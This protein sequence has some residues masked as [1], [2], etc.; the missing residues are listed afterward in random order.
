MR[1]A[2]LMMYCCF[3]IWTEYASFSKRK[4]EYRDL[5]AFAEF[6]ADVNYEYF[7]CKSVTEAIF[8]AAEKLPKHLKHKVEEICYLL[9]DE[10]TE[11]AAPDFTYPKH[12]KH[13]KLFLVLCQNA[14]RF[15]SGGSGE[16]ATFTKNMTELRKDVQI[17]CMKRS[18]AL[19]LFSGLGLI[20]AL[21][22][23]TL[24]A[25]RKW[26]S[27]N[28]PELKSFY[29][30]FAGRIVV[31]IIWC[32]TLL[33]YLLIRIVRKTDGNAYR[34]P[35]HIC[36]YFDQP[37]FHPIKNRLVGTRAEKIGRVRLLRAG[38]VRDGAEYW[39]ACFSVGVAVQ[40]ISVVLS[41]GERGV[42]VFIVSGI[43]FG[44]GFLCMMFF[45]KY[46]AYVRSLGVGTEVLGLQSILLMLFEAPNM[47]I[48]KL[49]ES[50]EE[51]SELFH[52]EILACTDRYASEENE[53]IKML[54]QNNLPKEFQR[55][56]HRLFIAEKI[57]IRKAFAELA[58]DRRYFRDVWKED[59]EKEMSGRAANAQVFAFAPLFIILFAY[60]IIPFLYSSLGQ[61][62]N[63]FSEMNQMR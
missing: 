42:R 29:D 15:G 6:L 30:G 55:L 36:N 59:T 19:F 20:A 51:Y 10:E 9:E 25:V 38:I 58:A 3:V 50:M 63:I 62:S 52:R 47:T 26:G 39:I 7:V 41:A 31:L 27:T 2:L 28:L 24:S 61:M 4:K 37:F 34:R 48:G 49:L 43:S 22:V 13:L 11:E 60:L 53:A 44:A 23:A 54:E 45:Y 33:S 57:G 46:L 8:Q 14:V 40:V 5:D 17:E 1:A 35:K 21:P 56:S 16:E 12:M 18:E 32:A